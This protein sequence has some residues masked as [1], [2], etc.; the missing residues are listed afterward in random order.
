MGV[1]S[2]GIGQKLSSCV[3]INR[4]FKE[5]VVVRHGSDSP[6]SAPHCLEFFR[7]Q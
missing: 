7:M 2:K 6:R 3:D 1:S 5:D 4:C